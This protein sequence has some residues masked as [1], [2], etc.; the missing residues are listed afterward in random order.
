MK[1]LRTNLLMFNDKDLQEVI[2][3]S[4]WYCFKGYAP[5]L[6]RHSINRFKRSKYYPNGADK[7]LEVENTL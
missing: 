7:Y 3:N 5:L 4:V 1:V 6:N 2:E